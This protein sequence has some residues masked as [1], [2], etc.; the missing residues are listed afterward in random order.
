M[1]FT[2][3]GTLALIARALKLW[4]THTVQLFLRD[5]RES[6]TLKLALYVLLGA[7]LLL[8][9][10]VTLVQLD[11]APV[12]CLLGANYLA[13]RAPQM[14]WSYALLTL[15]TLPQ[16]AADL[17]AVV[18][19]PTLDVVERTARVAFLLIAFLKLVVL[20]GMF[21]MHTRVRFKLQFFE[22]EEQID[23]EEHAPP[24]LSNGSPADVGGYARRGGGG[25]EQFT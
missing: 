3:L 8:Y 25:Y 19:W 2:S 24:A 13:T 9:L 22:F 20:V 18:E 11:Y 21:L 4:D 1:L 23:E 7:Q 10:P 14:L 5:V 6:R 16:D 17:A 15:A 12:I